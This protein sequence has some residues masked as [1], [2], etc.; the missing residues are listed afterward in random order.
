M[1]NPIKVIKGVSKAIGKSN[2]KSSA[3]K[4]NA[5]RFKAAQGKSLAPKGYKTPSL[6]KIQAKGIAKLSVGGVIGGAITQIPE[7]KQSIKRQIK[8]AKKN[9]RK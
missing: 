9:K 6:A 4:A 8:E 1:A 2:A 5:R 7:V 3:K